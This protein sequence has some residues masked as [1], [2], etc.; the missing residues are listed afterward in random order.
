VVCLLGAPKGR[1]SVEDE[2]ADAVAVV[3]E[4]GLAV[5]CRALLH[6]NEFLFLP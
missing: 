5:L 4:Q 1:L 3:R 6:C 2:L